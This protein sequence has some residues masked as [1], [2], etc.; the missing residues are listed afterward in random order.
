MME[1]KMS[2]CQLES[3]SS[4]STTQC[5]MG[6]HEQRLAVPRRPYISREGNRSLMGIRNLADWS[7]VIDMLAKKTV[8]F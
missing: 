8:Y 6:S 4:G 5:L 1:S 3:W 2:I 7:S